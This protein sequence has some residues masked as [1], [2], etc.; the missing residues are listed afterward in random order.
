[1]NI[2]ETIL[3]TGDDAAVAVFYRDTA[4]TYRE[5][6]Q[7]VGR[8]AG[9]LLARGHVKGD[10]IG[11][12]SEN[13]L[14]FVTAYL[15][16][17][18]AGLVAVPFQTDLPRE[19][20]EKIVRDAGIREMF[21]SKRF[22][23]PLRPWAEKAGVT[24]LAEPGLEQMTGEAAIQMPKI[25]SR[26]DLAVLMFTSGSTGVPKGVMVSH[27]N[28][29]CNTRDI[30]SYLG[31][32]PKDRAMVVLPFHYCFGISLLHTHLLAGA[33]VVLNNGF[34]LYPEEVLQEMQQRE[35]TGLAGVPST[36]QILL[37]KSRFRELS[38]PALRWFQ[39][40]GGKLPN[41][42]I[43]EILGSFPAV[44]FFLM[45]GQTE[46]TARLSYLPPERLGDKLGS[47]GKSLPSLRLDVLKP[48]GT[49]VS[50][51]SNETGEIVAAGDNVT[52]GYWND[53]EETAKY[54]RNG[55]LHTG[56]IARVD[57]DGFIFVV[58]RERELI[59]S[60][61]NRVSAKEV[62]DGIA[63]LPEVVEV[64]VLGA[65]HELL[66]EAIKAFVVVAPDAKIM[67]GAVEAHCRKRL[68]PFKSPEE[69]L[70]LKTMPHNGSGKVLKLKLRELIANGAKVMA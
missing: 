62:E 34:K 29:E 36:Y 13:S 54:F 27:R 21:A 52:L 9:G 37:R 16:T 50:L 35:C 33:S 67:P 61:G 47:I 63:E 48:D 60:G 6:R 15:A 53:P 40:A 58:E 14:F 56:D 44:R 65:P 51:G 22:F 23:N 69:I 30:I 12:W 2:A 55:R 43:T 57:A 68:P 11:L 42:Y 26:R 19:T 49:P 31:L 45:Y 46:A 5:L 39:Q 32:T 59:K 17:I 70:F 64:A 25:D 66:G 4:L 24:L 38:F 20:F 1:M 41:P 3:S 18:R 10:R 28:I 8:L 7:Q